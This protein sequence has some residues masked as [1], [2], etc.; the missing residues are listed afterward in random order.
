MT[1]HDDLLVDR[2]TVITAA[3]WSTPAIMLAA[4][5]PMASASGVAPLDTTA[6]VLA[7]RVT[8]PA[9]ESTSSA[10]LTPGFRF[11]STAVNSVDM[12]I[13][14]TGT[15]A[16]LAEL[17]T[18]YDSVPWSTGT[19]NNWVATG[20]SITPAKTL[21]IT[22]KAIEK[23]VG[24][25]TAKIFIHGATTPSGTAIFTVYKDGAN[26]RVRPGV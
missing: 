18:V 3:A 25:Y 26:F 12:T 11:S 13:T 8:G 1:D 23:A 5:V 4:G 19:G 16:S 20:V 10:N 14:K 17:F 2:R 24:T 9:W 21:G 22:I 6:G 7:V 15:A